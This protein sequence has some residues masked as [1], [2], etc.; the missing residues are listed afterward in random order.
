MNATI[1]ALR[2]SLLR[3]S[4]LSA[5]LVLI[6]PLPVA[7]QQAGCGFQFGF[8][9]VRSLIPLVVGECLAN[10]AFNQ[11]NGNAEQPTTGG[12]LVWRKADNWTAF[13]N[14]HRTWLLGPHG[15]QERLNAEHFSWENDVTSANANENANSNA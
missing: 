14:G 5:A 6:T 15:L 9:A 11:T 3:T 7:A 13:T 4:L 12:L 2:D 8:A 10:E 1:C